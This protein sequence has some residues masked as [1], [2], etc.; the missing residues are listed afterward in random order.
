MRVFRKQPS[1]INQ[2]DIEEPE[3]DIIECTCEYP[4][5]IDETDFILTNA[6]LKLL[7]EK[8]DKYV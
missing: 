4:I 3:K 2:V 5:K 7:S 8:E 6:W 1:I